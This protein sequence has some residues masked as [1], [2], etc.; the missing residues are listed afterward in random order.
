MNRY[1]KYQRLAVKITC[2]SEEGSG[3]LFQPATT[4]FTYVLTAKHCLIGKNN[5]YASELT[6]E[7]IVI[8][9][10]YYTQGTIPVIRFILHPVLDIAIVLVHFI[11]D[12]PYI[13]CSTP[14]E[15][16][17]LNCFGYPVC[18]RSEGRQEQKIPGNL[19]FDSNKEFEFTSD[20]NLATSFKTELDNVVG[21]SGAGIFIEEAEELVLIGTLSRL[22]GEDGVYGSL[23][24]IKAHS[25]NEILVDENLPLLIPRCL[26]SFDDYITSA[27]EHHDLHIGSVLSSAASGVNDITPS[28]IYEELREKV[29]LPYDHRAPLEPELWMGWITLLTYLH[30]HQGN[31]ED[32]N[33]SRLHLYYSKK[34]KHLE[35]VVR[36]IFLRLPNEDIQE[37]DCVIL[38]HQGSPGQTLYLDRNKVRGVLKTIDN[39]SLY[40]KGIYIDQPNCSKDI[41]ILNLEYFTR[42]FGNCKCTSASKELEN[43]LREFIREVFH[44]VS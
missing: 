44:E 6:P 22:K 38:K 17:K 34:I 29:F 2:F 23:I 4:D 13:Y 9:N 15:N 20:V 11:G 26:C 10:D 5:E 1:Q 35:E 40:S 31:T 18:L 30:I 16:H 32:I 25:Y 36:H 21:L 33:H 3:C 39:N 28:K 43:E 37:N 19:L 42:K 41:T 7:S 24:G 27:F 8:T 14:K 12:L